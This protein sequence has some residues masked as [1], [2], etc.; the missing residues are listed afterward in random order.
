M[1]GHSWKLLLL[2]SIVSC[3]PHPYVAQDG[4]V[5]LEGIHPNETTIDPSN[6]DTTDPKNPEHTT[7][8]PK[9]VEELFTEVTTIVESVPTSTAPVTTSVTTTTSPPTTVSEEVPEST[10]PPTTAAPS[11]N[12]PTTPPPSQRTS[13]NSHHED[14]SK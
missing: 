3:L 12:P 5:E 13:D 1:A 2:L 9:N 10:S 8:P 14:T 7:F 11:E 4:T 6:E